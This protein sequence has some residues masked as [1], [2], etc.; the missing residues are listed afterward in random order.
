M[1]PTCRGCEETHIK[2]FVVLRREGELSVL[3]VVFFEQ[4]VALRVYYLVETAL[5]E[6]ESA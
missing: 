1:T 6:Y 4:R 3:S 2:H 5:V